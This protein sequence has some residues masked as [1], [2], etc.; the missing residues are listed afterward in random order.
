MKLG[1][2]LRCL[3]A[4]GSPGGG[5][6]HAARE[7]TREISRLADTV[8]YVPNGAIVNALQGVKTSLVSLSG[9]S[10]RSL[11]C[12]ISEYPCD[13]LFVPSGAVP[14]GMRIPAYPWVHD[15]DIFF[16]PEWFPQ[17]FFKRMLTTSMV[18]LGLKKAPAVFVVSEYAKHQ[19]ERV[20]FVSASCILVTGEGGDAVLA[21]QQIISRSEMKKQTLSVLSNK[22]LVRPFA[23]VLGTLE[24]RK[25]IQHILRL[26]PEV[27]RTFP[28]FDL[29]IAGADG[30]CT[31]DIYTAMGKAR[32]H[33]ASDILH[34]KDL[35][36]MERRALLLHASLVL[37]PSLSE[38]FGLVALEAVQ[39][40][41]P[42]V[43]SGRG[44][45]VEV[46]GMGPW[47]IDPLDEK[48]WIQGI[49]EIFGNTTIR[50]TWIFAQAAHA[51]R[52]SWTHA[53][54]IIV[55]TIHERHV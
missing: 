53:A 18:K 43:T 30:W 26:W 25:N 40:G 51:Q 45:L 23:L 46:V 52:W 22:G 5:I 27:S 29:V 47:N 7:I 4:D 54:E 19:V 15:M 48:A 16:H 17:S 12:A 42:V 14:F 36:D 3:P 44:A 50:Q 10:R 8:L 28:G 55:R 1:I 13:A 41:V 34:L 49:G 2:D 32:T 33:S 20:A 37:V 35:T 6:A 9:A 11:I 21:A 31:H 39:A 24:P 38:G